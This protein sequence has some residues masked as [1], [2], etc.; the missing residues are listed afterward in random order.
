[1]D[2]LKYIVHLFNS[3]GFVMYPLVIL[4]I[5]VIAIGIERYSY[6]KANTALLK[7]FSHDVYF[8]VKENDWAKAKELCVAN[9][10]ATGR[11]LHAGLTYSQTETSMKNAFSEQMMIE[12]SHLKIHLDYLS[13]IVT[14]SPL[15]GLL[16]TVSGMIGTFSILDSGSGASAISGGVGE[17]LI[18][19]ATGL[20]VAILSFCVYTYF[21]HRMDSIINDTETLSVVLLN[22]MKEQWSDSHVSK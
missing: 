19:T 12:A 9:Q 2:S 3:G 10:T 22:G 15:L 17:A 7:E 13:A 4:S 6:F 5:I 21:S 8:A 1:M 14:I 18:A 16:G 11:I 20:L